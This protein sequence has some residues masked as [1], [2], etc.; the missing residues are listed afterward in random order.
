MSSHWSHPQARKT[1]DL[2]APPNL[3]HF[4]D[5]KWLK[6]SFA[7]TSQSIFP[8]FLAVS[9][10]PSVLLQQN[11][12]MMMFGGSALNPFACGLV[13]SDSS[14]LAA[15]CSAP[16]SAAFSPSNVMNLPCPILLEEFCLHYEISESDKD[17]LALLEVC[18][19]DCTVE[20]LESEYW[21]E[22]SFSWLGWG[23][24]LIAHKQFV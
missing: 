4:S 17:K 3:K 12:A 24:F 16:N 22:V 10:D 15:S 19:G 23:R 2:K 5:E 6:A 9:M 14:T 8:L 21:K 7:T 20:K 18:L 1:T 13:S 11:V